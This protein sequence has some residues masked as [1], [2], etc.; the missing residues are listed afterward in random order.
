MKNNWMFAI[1]LFATAGISHA[2]NLC[3]INPYT[4]AEAEQGRIAFESRCAL[5]HQY[6][7]T[8]R[9]PGNFRNESPDINLLSESDLKFLDGSGGAV[10]PLV[11]D[12]FF[13]KQQGKTLAEFS[14]SVSGAANT[15]PPK[16]TVVPLTYFQVAAYVLYRNCGRL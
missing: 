1:A 16:N 3:A 6:N 15:F 13:G 4:K 12:R 5:C 10:P 8:G 14:A 9:V 11:G 2:D 7:L